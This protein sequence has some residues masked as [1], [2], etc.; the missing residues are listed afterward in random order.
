MRY[1]RLGLVGTFALL[2]FSI[3]VADKSFLLVQQRA[4]TKKAAAELLLLEANSVSDRIRTMEKGAE[5]LLELLRRWT[6][7]GKIDFADIP[8]ANALLMGYMQQHPFISSINYGDSEGNGYLLLLQEGKWLNRIKSKSARGYVT[9]HE[10]KEDGTLLTSERRPDDYD[11]RSRP[12]YTQAENALGTTW[13]APYLFRT[14]RDPG[15]TASLRVTPA[16]KKVVGVVGVDVMLQDLSAFLASIKQ[17]NPDIGIVI[18]LPDESLMAA[19][20][21]TTFK[22]HLHKGSDR[23]PR[24]SD[25]GFSEMQAVAAAFR[26]SPV[27]FV[28]AREGG[29]N[30]Y[31]QRIRFDFSKDI[32]VDL[33]LAIPQQAMLRRF[34]PINITWLVFAS[35]FG[36]LLCLFFARHYLRPV[37][38]LTRAIRS[39]GT[40]SY[41]RPQFEERTDEI[42]ILASEFNRMTDALHSERQRLI[43]SEQRYRTLFESVLDGVYATDRE[44][45]F[46]KANRA[47][48]RIFG[49]DS[50]EA[51]LGKDVTV[52]WLEPDDR[53]KF[54]ETLAREKSVQAYPVTIK[55][56]D[57]EIVHLAVSSIYLEDEEGTYLGVEGILR[58]ITGSVRQSRAL[59]AAVQEWQETFDAISDYVSIHDREQRIVKANRAMVAFFGSQG[60]ELVGKKCHEIYHPDQQPCQECPLRR[61]TQSK[62]PATR[63]ISETRSG[64]PLLVTT[65]PILDAGQEL[66]GYVHV[67]KDLSERKSL[68]AQLL[69]AQKMEAVGRLAGGIAHDFNNMLSVIIGYGEMLL[70][71][72]PQVDPH[73]SQI[74]EIVKA[75]KRSAELT[76]QLLAFARKQQIR[77]L[78]L[79][80][81][82]TIHDRARM[83]SRLIGE[84]IELRF[85][86]GP[87]LWP[88]YL[89][90]LQLD[91][92]LVNLAVNSR[93]AIGDRHGEIVI[94]T[95]NV[96]FDGQG[97]PPPQE[98]RPGEY[99][100]M[101]F[102]DNGCGIAPHLVP[103]I[104]EPFF[105][106]K[107]QG[108]GTGLGLAMVFGIVSQNNGFISLESVEG[109][110]TRFTFFF[111]RYKEREALPEAADAAGSGVSLPG[112]TETILLAE[113]EEGVRLYVENLL[114]NLGYTVL[115]A[116]T[117]RAALAI[118]G[119]HQGSIDLLLSD[120]VMPGMNGKELWETLQPMRAGLRCLFMSGYPEKSIIDR[121]LLVKDVNYIQKPFSQMELAAKIRAVL[122]GAG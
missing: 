116:D 27:D 112:G 87:D 18:S 92:I 40:D 103:H 19:S 120:V 63:E 43:D 101:L 71:A 16:G 96:E 86:L 113:D 7:R 104:Y 34:Q 95:S 102:S 22:Y 4:V 26:K 32:V 29:R 31:A 122:N 65:Y 17:N 60:V 89:D 83:I 41:H 107:E 85:H 111:P 119:Q 9:W 76:R 28:T 59:A 81:N 53:R 21:E 100:M 24:L 3:F 55:R 75:G 88:I 105:S 42:G 79:D 35:L 80:L 73:R 33:L 49:F 1:L 109:K 37:Q 94:E 44:S 91:Q 82:N 54:V 8:A 39:F 47:C 97:N 14:T 74:K 67:A 118:A 72:M 68:E 93:D 99:V 84:D 52:Y 56:G 12:W 78:V 106:T 38:L 98:G 58:D 25:Q 2:I 51:L 121:G 6:E 66:V 45:R 20:D 46:V 61:T 50:P 70:Y 114:G 11:P 90:P 36:I 69:H 15:I 57:G 77:P 64:K 13:S 110:G 48:A 108:K 30:F 5:Q 117:P 115:S 62:A 23:L 10:V